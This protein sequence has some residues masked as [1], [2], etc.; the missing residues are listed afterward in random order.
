MEG[1]LGALEP[2]LSELL[3]YL[4]EQF[5]KSTYYWHSTWAYEP[6][7]TQESSGYSVNNLED[8][9]KQYQ[10]LVYINNEISK[11]YSLPQIPTGDA[12]QLARQYG[13]GDN[14][15]E[16]IQGSNVIN[17]HYHDGDLGGGQ[18]LNACV[19]FEILTGQS[20]VGN[21]WRPD[22]V[23]SEDKIAVLQ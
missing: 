3:E 2:Y 19:W 9:T 13:V 10:D 20:R 17:D 12:W 14:L 21:T 7:F 8:Q 6:G 15:C 1:A 18:Y 23:L 22:Y 11:G 16:R 5:P 4:K